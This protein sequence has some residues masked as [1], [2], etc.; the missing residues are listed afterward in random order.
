MRR[1]TGRKSLY[2]LAVSILFALLLHACGGS[3]STG[4]DASSRQREVLIS[5][6]KTEVADLPIWLESVGQVHSQS[7][8]TLAA[9]VGGRITR[10]LADT[11][12]RIEEGQLLAE[13]DT[14]TLLLQRQAARAALERLLVHIANGEKRVGRLETLSAKNLSSQTLLDDAREQL[15]AYRADQ[16]AAA[17]QLAIVEDSLTKSR[18][19]APV[20]GII[21]RRLVSAGDFVSRGQALFEITRPEKLQAWLPYPETVALEVKIGQTAKIHSPLTPGRL[22]TAT[23]SDLQPT[24]G[25]GSRAVMA[26]VDLEDPGE[27]RPGATISGQVLV[28]TRSQAVLVPNI[29]VVSRPAGESVYVIDGNR[30]EARL[31]ET[32]HVQG[33]LVE[34]VAGLVGGETLATDGAAF[35]TDGAQVKITEPVN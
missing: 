29:S 27:L 7:A 33:N 19:V 14:S 9:E 6:H 2:G 12:D 34:I 26:I 16:K 31:V 23:I 18:I 35:L 5:V 11:G 10:V 8:P 25:S 13:T 17:A 15:E 24:I 30:A 28:E 4:D 32:G 22:F 1:P 20:S 3:D 21:Q